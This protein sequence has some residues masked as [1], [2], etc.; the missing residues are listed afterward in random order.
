[1]RGA[2]NASKFALEGLVDTLR[3][4]LRDTGIKVAL[5]NPGAIQTRF[6]E[7]ALEAADAAIDAERS[8]HAARYAKLRALNAT[9]GGKTRGSLPPEAVAEQIRHALESGAPKLRYFSTA[10][11]RTLAVLKRILPASWLDALLAER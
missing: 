1:M 4:E 3:M 2:Y 8:V 6:R 11:A 10:P 7:H 5:I 9:P